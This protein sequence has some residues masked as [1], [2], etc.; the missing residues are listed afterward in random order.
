MKWTDVI[1]ISESLSEA[2]PDYF[3][4]DIKV[5]YFAKLQNMII[6]LKGFDDVKSN[7][8]EKILEVIQGC[9]ID[10]VKK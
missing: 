5:I 7:C 6:N 8:N 9:W 4:D 3:E 10:E 2:F 1:Q